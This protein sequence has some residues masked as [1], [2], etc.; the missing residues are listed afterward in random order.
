M[1]DRFLIS[2]C[3]YI[4]RRALVILSVIEKEDSKSSLT[5]CAVYERCTHEASFLSSI[6]ENLKNKNEL[7][8]PLLQEYRPRVKEALIKTHNNMKILKSYT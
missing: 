6:S 8:K 2:L 3:C 1:Q 4:A 5:G 7:K